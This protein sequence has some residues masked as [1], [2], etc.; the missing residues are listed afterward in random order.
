[1]TVCFV[2]F[3]FVSIRFDSF[4][5]PCF[6]ILHRLTQ[7]IFRDLYFGSCAVTEVAPA[8]EQLTNLTNLDISG[9]AL[10][11]IPSGSIAK[12]TE[13]K[14][15]NLSHNNLTE[16]NEGMWQLSRT[17]QYRVV[18]NDMVAFLSD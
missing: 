13:L 2:S 17:L 5:P 14:R 9:N 10:S 15:L 11:T 18:D 16:L 12:T 4:R 7:N 3:R 6:V 8:I 1:M